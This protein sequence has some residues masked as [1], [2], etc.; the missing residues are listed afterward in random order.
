MKARVVPVQL[1]RFPSPTGNHKEVVTD[2]ICSLS[3]TVV[4]KKNTMIKENYRWKSLFGFTVPEGLESILER[5]VAA[6][7]RKLRDLPLQVRSRVNW[8]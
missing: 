4:K 5:G 8:K 2:Y 3:V 7:D 6:R 1:P